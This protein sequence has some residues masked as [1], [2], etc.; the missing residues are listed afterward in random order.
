[1]TR[2]T[3]VLLAGLLSLLPGCA[4]HYA[5]LADRPPPPPPP[6]LP[7]GCG[8][9]GHHIYTG[10][11]NGAASIG[12]TI[13]LVNYDAKRGGFKHNAIDHVYYDL[14]S[15]TDYPGIA[16]SLNLTPVSAA[17]HPTV[18]VM[19]GPDGQSNYAITVQ[20]GDDAGLSGS[21]KQSQ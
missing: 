13:D 7:P 15:C 14:A 2:L 17:G 19:R 6:P 11:L 9:L 16:L 1:M 4:R 12:V 8:A 20:S 10:N 5:A 3:L 21:V 18:I